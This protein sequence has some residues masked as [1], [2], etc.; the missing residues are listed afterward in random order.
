MKQVNEHIKQS[1]LSEER[2]DSVTL[3]Y[4]SNG[5]MRA[6]LSTKTFNHVQEAKP[7]YILMS[8]GMKVQF[9]GP[10]LTPTSVLTA[11][12]GRYFEE[13]NNVLI[14][15]SVKVIN[16]KGETLQTDEL[17]W[18]EKLQV[19]FTEKA[20]TIT[21]ATQIIYGKGLEANQDF[22]KYKILQPTGIISVSKGLVPTN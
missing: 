5:V 6:I 17:I 14:K 18:N 9:Y 15:D 7:P 10:N 4:S 11:R 8:D 1:Q 22:T 2:A 12:S 21:T 13:D 3:Y 16:D 19:F 20:V